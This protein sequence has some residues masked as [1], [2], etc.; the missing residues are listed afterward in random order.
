MFNEIKHP[1][2]I[3]MKSGS[4][5]WKERHPKLHL[6]A[7]HAPKAYFPI[8]G[9]LYVTA[10]APGQKLSV[11]GVAARS[12]IAYGAPLAAYGAYKGI[13]KVRA[14]RNGGTKKATRKR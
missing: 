9:A 14:R 12:A 2:R 5:S 10:R 4:P 1:A 6:A 3:P 7:R 8:A 11:G 13:K